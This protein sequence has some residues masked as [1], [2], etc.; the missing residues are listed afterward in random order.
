MPERMTPLE[1]MLRPATPSTA[2][3]ALSSAAELLANLQAQGITPDQAHAV[4]NQVLQSVASSQVQ[5]AQTFSGLIG[6]QEEARRRQAMAAEAAAAAQQEELAQDLRRYTE[7]G[8]RKSRLP[9]SH[10]LIRENLARLQQLDPH[11]AKS[12][13]DTAEDIQKINMARADLRMKKIMKDRPLSLPAE[14]QE[15]LKVSLA[16]GGTARSQALKTLVAHRKQAEQAEALDVKRQ[17]V[18]QRFEKPAKPVDLIREKIGKATTLEE[19]STLMPEVETTARKASTRRG[20]VKG[21]GG[22]AAALL[23]GMVLSKL[24]SPGEQT[25]DPMMMQML[26]SQGG[27]N[28]NETPASVEEGR[29]LTN[30]MR[31]MQIQK[32][33]QETMGVMTPG[34]V[35][36]II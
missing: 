31:V 12:L 22:L 9:L 17:E 35:G 27:R 7:K 4:L 2:V 26:L 32:L 18:L 10:P 19:L 30:L 8:I 5:T 20:L 11:A 6:Q 28:T 14:Q 21:A 36:G 3:N 16:S 34:A 24:S 13:Q 1:R 23:G 25:M 29:Q 33:L 15:A